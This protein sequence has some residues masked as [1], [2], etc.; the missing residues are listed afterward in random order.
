MKIIRHQPFRA[1]LADAVFMLLTT[2]FHS[3][4]LSVVLEMTLKCFVPGITITRQ[5]S[6][7]RAKLKKWKQQMIKV[8]STSNASGWASNRKLVVIP[9]P[10]PLTIY[11][12]NP[13]TRQQKTVFV[14]IYLDRK[15]ACLYGLFVVFT[16][17]FGLARI[18]V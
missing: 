12:I 1:S 13:N 6:Y 17:N 10:K 15:K 8:I 16:D 14:L 4:L 5:L 11:S 7:P 9:Y 2:L 18:K 3:P